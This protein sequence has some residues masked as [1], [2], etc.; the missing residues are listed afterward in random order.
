MKIL[1]F[2]HVSTA[3]NYYRHWQYGKHLQLRGHE[4]G[5]RPEA[6]LE[7]F[8]YK[9]NANH[10][11]H[12][13]I[14]KN[15]DKYEALWSTL[16]YEPQQLSMLFGLREALSLI[17]G[18]Y[19]PLF[20]DIDDL[21][22][23]IPSYNQAKDAIKRNS[24]RTKIALVSLREADFV[25]TTCKFLADKVKPYN[26][27]IVILP[28]C[29]EPKLWDYPRPKKDD[30]RLRILWSGSSARFGD[31]QMLKDTLFWLHDKYADKVKL[32][33]TGTCPDFAVPW[34]E[35]GFVYVTRWAPLPDYM[36][37]MRYIAP[38]IGL[39]PLVPN[40]FNRS[41]SPLKYLDHAMIGC[42]GVYSQECTYECV[43]DKHTGLFAI[44]TPSWCAAIEELINNSSLRKRIIKASHEDVM[45]RFNIEKQIPT[46]ESSLQQALNVRSSHTK[47]F[48][49]RPHAVSVC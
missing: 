43:E 22:T 44:D 49:D 37:V 14:L 27:R 28:N 31:I 26:E 32:I 40:D 24:D 29:V 46:I 16:P 11:S 7:P 15:A 13:W 5:M 2:P 25:T 10:L 17:H 9:T 23:E 8:G 34:V 1:Q 18:K 35:Q 30:S 21:V 41:K 48:L 4:V 3:I 39:A 12:D 36:M 33:L 42:A 45:T 47:F 19:C 6:S 38:D 20:I